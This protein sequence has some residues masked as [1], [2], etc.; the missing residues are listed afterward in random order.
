MEEE[1]RAELNA[2]TSRPGKLA[3]A[4]AL[5]LTPRKAFVALGEEA[6]AEINDRSVGGLTMVGSWKSLL[7]IS[8]ASFGLAAYG[9]SFLLP[10]RYA[11]EALIL[12]RP[13]DVSKDVVQSD[14]EEPIEDRLAR[15][16]AQILSRRSLIAVLNEFELFEAN[17]SRDRL[18]EKL[19]R[20]ITVTI[21][22]PLS[23][24][25]SLVPIS[26]RQTPPLQ[27]R[28]QNVEG[29]RINS[30]T[31][32]YVG[33]EPLTAEK[34]TERVTHLFLMRH[35]QY[36]SERLFGTEEFLHSEL[37]KLAKRLTEKGNGAGAWESRGK[38]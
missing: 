12:I 32:R 10:V 13:Q 5:M 28:P 8:T 35:Q 33:S 30:L 16:Q 2:I 14:P 18:V 23:H 15:F 1:W 7:I 11:S 3:F 26:A 4:I 25:S 20:D 9:L 36:R 21:A 17:E 19:R 24:V 22:T 38:N 34:V 37:E 31:I 6:I 27:Q 29:S